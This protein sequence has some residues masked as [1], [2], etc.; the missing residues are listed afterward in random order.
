MTT[1]EDHPYTAKERDDIWTAIDNLQSAIS[2]IRN[3]VA[4]SMT[5]DDLEHLDYLIKT[6][7]D[8]L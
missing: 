6:V 1:N 8:M 7:V 3:V 2:I 5:K 4:F